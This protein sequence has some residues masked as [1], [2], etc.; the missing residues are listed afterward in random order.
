MNKFAPYQPNYGTFKVKNIAEDRKTIKIFLYPIN[1]NSVRDLL[2]IPGVSESDI[3][4]SL[5]KGELLRKIQAREI[6]IIESDIDLLQ[7]NDNQKEFLQNA[8][9]I[10]G[11]E[12]S[13]GIGGFDKQDIE[14]IG[15]KDNVNTIF[16]TPTKF[17]HNSQF[18]EVLYVNALRQ[19]SPEDYLISE[20]VVGEGYDIITFVV[21]PFSDDLLIIDYFEV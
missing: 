16:A 18:K 9:I 11:L 8:G 13:G 17:K 3:R 19:H 7:F 21:P 1:F 12:I 15:T 14:L 5:L 6:S 10:N 4:A 2:K 20:S